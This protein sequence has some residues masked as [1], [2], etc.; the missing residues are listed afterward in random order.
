M[1]YQLTNQYKKSSDPGAH[2]F[3]HP[4]SPTHRLY[5]A[6]RALLLDRQSASLVARR[7]RYQPSTLHVLASKL[8]TGKLPPFF[9][10][11]RPGPKRQ[12]KKELV[13]QLAIPLRKTNHSVYDIQR[14]LREQGHP[15]SIR[16]IWEILRDAGFSRLPRRLDEE[17]PTQARPIPADK[18][19]RRL[20]HLEP[21]RFPTRAGGLFL[22]LPFLT[23]LRFDHLVRQAG[24]PATRAIP[25]LQYILSLLSLKLL[26]KER[27]SH[28]MDIVH[29]PGVGFFCGLNVIPKTT[30]LTTYSYRIRRKQNL[31]LLQVWNQALRQS[32][33]VS[34][35]SFHLDFHTIAHFGE[36]AIL[37]KNYVP[38][39][40]HAEK[41]VLTFL[42]Q[43][44]ASTVLCYSHA[45]ILKRDQA[46]EVLA[47]VDFW[48]KTTGRFPSEVIFDSKLTTQKNLSRLNQLG[49]RFLTLRRKSPKEV[50]RLMSLPEEAWT[51]CDLDTLGRK[52]SHPKVVEETLRLK[53]YDGPLRQ[54]AAKDLGRDLPTL[55]ITNDRKQKAGGLL[56]RYAKRMLIENAI[57]DG[58]HFFHLD[59]LCS[60]LRVEVDF[61]VVLTV[62]ANGLYRLLA[63]K[64]KGF[65]NA[66]AKQLHRRLIDTAAVIQVEEGGEVQVRLNLR[67]HN[68][69]LAEAG[70]TDSAVRVPWLGDATVRVTIPT[71]ARKPCSNR[72]CENPG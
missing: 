7:F 55:L 39:R 60:S 20:F 37:E 64:I 50:R 19:D 4:T 70:L 14:I 54:I 72:L 45:G 38:R 71:D 11:H 25:A 59:A 2:F 53:G 43:D 17:R 5:E 35:E 52:Y 47:F 8:R 62:I 66:T 46:D 27:I 23:S 69:L 63:R 9:V 26:S 40:S 49:I 61:S 6:L 15:I 65:E 42:A 36:E 31:R 57:A 24:Y 3:A 30:A 48:K 10:A 29:D 44:E 1:Y 22:F 56:A 68:P 13:S 21:A 12:P 16:A 58:V 67:A 51:R 18:A 34:G 28:V 41:S 33:W 32:G